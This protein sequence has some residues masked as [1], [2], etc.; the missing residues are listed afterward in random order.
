MTA[1]ARVL[2]CAP[3]R[4]DPPRHV[5]G[6]PASGRPRDPYHRS[7][8]C[9]RVHPKEVRMTQPTAAR[10]LVD[11]LLAQGVDTVFGVP[12]ESYLA[13][14]DALHDVSDRVR[15]I[16]N[17]HEGGAALHG[18]GL[19][20]ADRPTWRGVRHPRAGRDQRRERG[21]H[22]HA[23]RHAAR[24]LRRPGR[25]RQPRSRR[26]AGTGL[27][28][29]LFRAREMGRRDRRRRPRA[30][31]CRPRIRR[32]QS[33]RPGPVVVALPEDMLASPTA[34]IAGPLRIPRAVPDPEAI[35]EIRCPP[36][37]GG[38]SAC[39]GRRGR[40]DRRRPPGAAVV[41]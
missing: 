41:R 4:S 1:P 40:L 39:P 11:C 7:G 5:L 33:G 24:A 26:L 6:I 18:R 32:G 10:V 36:R 16:P 13:V 12:G 23:G 17:R 35:A 9:G 21:A 14:L 20:Q 25:S 29:G 19:G 2:E 37:R 28:R 3:S 27:S 8:K 31:D 22:R 38:H 34:A 15:L 30:R